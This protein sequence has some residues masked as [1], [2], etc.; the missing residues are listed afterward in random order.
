MTMEMVASQQD[1]NAVDSVPERDAARFQNQ[2]GRS[3]I[4]PE[5]EV[6]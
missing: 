2:P 6:S 4:S 5:S 1:E 3:Q